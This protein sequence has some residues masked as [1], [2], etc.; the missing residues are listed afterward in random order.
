MVRQSR[1]L[2][3][4]LCAVFLFGCGG[5]SS[6]DISSPDLVELN[7][8]TPSNTGNALPELRGLLSN[9][10]LAQERTVFVFDIRDAD[11]DAVSVSLTSPPDW[12]TYQVSNDTLTVTVNPDF[13]DIGNYRIDTL[14]SDGK[15]DRAYVIEFAVDDN[16]ARYGSIRITESGLIGTHRF[17][18]RDVLHLYESGKGLFVDIFKNEFQV[19]WSLNRFGQATI[20]F[21][22]VN[23]FACGVVRDYALRIVAQQGT[24]QRWVLTPTDED[25]AIF[26]SN[27]V[28]LVEPE[29]VSGAYIGFGEVVD[30]LGRVDT[31]N[32]RVILPA[33]V[34]TGD[35]DVNVV[36]DA[37]LDET[38]RQGLFPNTQA[39]FPLHENFLKSF[40]NQHEGTF[41]GLRFDLYPHSLEIEYIDANIMKVRF[42]VLP[43]LHASNQDVVVE[44]FDVSLANYLN[45]PMETQA[46][47]APLTPVDTEFVFQAGN[48][49][50]S[51]FDANTEAVINQFTVPVSG[52]T[53]LTLTSDLQGQLTLN[54]PGRPDSVSTQDAVW[55]V[56]G[57]FLF[58]AGAEGD[59]VYELFET[60]HGERLLAGHPSHGEYV[61]IYPLIVQ[62]D[63]NNEDSSEDMSDVEPLPT[64][65]ELEGKY[66]HVTDEDFFS[67]QEHYF[68]TEDNRMEYRTINSTSLWMDRL[69]VQPDGSM[70]VILGDRQCRSFSKTYESCRQ[71]HES[72]FHNRGHVYELKRL[73]LVK[74]EDD[75][76][77]FSEHSATLDSRLFGRSYAQSGIRVLRRIEE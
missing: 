63:A 47:F 1:L 58:L 36:F 76:Y 4:L 70:E 26:A 35:Y 5:S 64:V 44:D 2:F 7:N 37:T 25:L 51:R 77:Y 61:G 14:L 22:D 57:N 21:Y 73:E 18:S 62:T 15:S 55:Q 66:V 56:A 29:F 68:F 12:L 52:A 24:S 28:E 8:A 74:V 53:K 54:V 72:V 65:S 69:A 39:Q 9:R 23:C 45:V 17:Q 43:R 48:T 31:D 40:F 13:F 75:K 6:A 32:S 19:R 59:Q 50:Y 3:C 10:V 27:T 38:R 11:D 46:A 60:M 71:L 67:T 42:F 20:K 16:P 49:Y 30:V 33:T 34:S 41:L